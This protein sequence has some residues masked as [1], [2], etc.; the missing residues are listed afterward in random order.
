MMQQKEAMQSASS[1]DRSAGRAED[2]G[3]FRHRFLV[4]LVYVIRMISRSQ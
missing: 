4:L 2:N 3:F 1:A